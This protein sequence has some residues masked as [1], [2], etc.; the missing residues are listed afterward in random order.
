MTG[1]IP[2]YGGAA[3]PGGPTSPY[4]GAAAPGGPTPPG[5]GPLPPGGALA[6]GGG[7]IRPLG[8]PVPPVA[9]V[10]PSVQVPT[11]M[12]VPPASDSPGVARRIVTILV[13]LLVVGGLAYIGI[14][15]PMLEERQWVEGACIDYYPR[16]TVEEGIDPNVVAC[17]D[18]R[19]RARIVRV[20][21]GNASIERDCEPLGSYALVDRKKADYCIVELTS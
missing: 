14:I 16:G 12:G 3:A 10:P 21:E 6:P 8:G 18:D 13:A 20:V 15:R 4:G 17:S 7:P 9:P 2:P 19:A 1:S 11:P 5:G